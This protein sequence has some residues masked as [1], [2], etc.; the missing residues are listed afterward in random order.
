M[1][2]EVGAFAAIEPEYKTVRGWNSTTFGVRDAAKLPSAAR[3]YLKFIAEHLGVEIGMISTGPDR[4]AT[5]IPA[6]TQLESWLR[7]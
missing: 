3:D 2:A 7:T 4:D 1:P 6:G 5:I